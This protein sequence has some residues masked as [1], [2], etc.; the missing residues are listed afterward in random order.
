MSRPSPRSLLAARPALSAL[1]AALALSTAACVPSTDA[2]RM[3]SRLDAPWPDD[4]YEARKVASPAA[5]GKGEAPAVP[6]TPKAFDEDRW[7]A[8]VW[9]GLAPRVAPELS[10]ADPDQGGTSL[11][12]WFDA[13]PVKGIDGANYVDAPVLGISTPDLIVWAT[14]AG[15]QLNK[16]PRL[17]STSSMFTFRASL[18]S[19]DPVTFEFGDYDLFSS[20]DYMGRIDGTYPGRV[21]F[22]VRGP[23]GVAECRAAF[24][25]VLAV[26]AKEA[27]TTLDAAL[28]RLEAHTPTLEQPLSPDLEAV[29]TALGAVEY[30]TARGGPRLAAAQGR[31][32]KASRAQWARYLGLVQRAYLDAAPAGQ[33]VQVASYADARVD[34]LE[35]RIAPAYSAKDCAPVLELRVRSEMGGA[36]CPARGDELGELGPLRLLTSDG[37][38]AGVEVR[39]VRVGDRYLTDAMDLT[40]QLPGAVLRLRVSPSSRRESEA[41]WDLP[42]MRVGKTYLRVH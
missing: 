20:N 13:T 42:L 2:C 14:F 8:A 1:G 27:A 30:F 24:G 33:W 39:H 6:L 26:H 16:G 36:L 9:A 23:A 4:K 17:F 31:V 11:V 38:V 19:G 15:A 29:E 3:Q 25:D 40:R 12:C 37:R 21:P 32:D 18:R 34:G 41:G 5:V 35:C 10:A 7:G 22:T 28:A